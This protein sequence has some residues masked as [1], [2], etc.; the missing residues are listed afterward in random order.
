MAEGTPWLTSNVWA[1]RGMVATGHPMASQAGLAVLHLGG[2]AVDAAVASALVTAVVM[3][4]MC[5]LGGDCFVLYSDPSGTVHSIVGS[6]ALPLSF[7]ESLLHATSKALLPLRGGASVA[8]PGA[9][10]AYQLLHQRFGRL[11]WADVVYPAVSLARDGFAVDVGLSQDLRD[12]QEELMQDGAAAA[13]FFPQ[14][15]PLAP[16]EI[17][18]QPELAEWLKEILEAG[19]SCFYQG[20]MAEAVAQAVHAAGGF[21][22]ADDLKAYRAQTEPPLAMEVGGFTVFASPLPSAGIILLEALA[23]VGRGG[24]SADWRE[25]PEKV[26][27]VI[28]ALRW[29]FYDRRARLGDPDFTSF[30][31]ETLI[32]PMHIDRRWAKIG[33][34]K[35]NLPMEPQ[36]LAPEGDTTSLVAVDQDGGSVSLIHSLGLAF[37]SQVY[38]SRGG[39]FL[40][41]RAGRS[42][43]LIPGHPNQALPGKRPMHTLNT[44]LVQESGRTLLVGNT[45]GGDGQPQW[46]LTILM[47]LLWGGRSPAEAVAM[48]R[49]TVLPATDAH[50][51]NDREQVQVESRFSPRVWNELGRR[52]HV[53]QVIGPYA[54]GGSVQVIR[55]VGEG[56]VGASDPRAS[57][58]TIGF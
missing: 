14:D 41:N 30:R 31:A 13:R 15:R 2:N 20:P 11:T 39:F 42:F 16:G 56:L 50:T 44:Y 18:V 57:G 28:E 23:I 29:S 58:Q 33:W 4:Q 38:V 21:L 35:A 10:D 55:R 5:G 36:D 51:L 43:N 22:S 9:L 45:P 53:V 25:D 8:V 54:G 48:P 46:N 47:D 49:L 19:S 24:F 26:H 40:N 52:G 1:R 3:P 32:D 7:P 34:Q 27:Q 17:L 37:G 6:G 12:N